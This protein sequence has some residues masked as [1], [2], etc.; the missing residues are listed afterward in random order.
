MLQDPIQKGSGNLRI[1]GASHSHVPLPAHDESIGR[2]FVGYHGLCHDAPGVCER[3]KTDASR[4]DPRGRI[5]DGKGEETIRAT[6]G[7]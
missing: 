1:S 5:E 6:I 4:I 7:I 3:V 2:R